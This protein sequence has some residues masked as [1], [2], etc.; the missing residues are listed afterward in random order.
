VL[1]GLTL[2]AGVAAAQTAPAQDAAAVVVEPVVAPSEAF[3]IHG[4]VHSGSTKLPGVT[5]TA[6][7][8]LTGRKVITSTD[9]DGSFRIELPFKGRWALRAEFFAFAV[10]T[11]EL[12]LTP[13][14]PQATHDFE[15]VLQSRVP[16]TTGEEGGAVD[17][18]GGEKQRAGGS[19]VSGR[20]A[21]RLS[22]NADDAALAQSASAGEGDMSPANVSGLAASEDATNQSVSVSGRMGNAQDLGVPNMDD[23]RDRIAEM[24]ASGQLGAGGFDGGGGGQGG[25]GFG[26][27]GGGGGPG[28]G[29]GGRMRMGS[30][31]KPHGQIYYTAS[32][33]VLDAAPY[34]VSGPAEKPAYG[35]NKIGA[36]I[37][38]VLKIPH[39]YDDGGK[40]F[41]FLNYSGIRS[42]TPYDVFSHV[43]TQEERNG[44]FANTFVNGKQVELYDPTNP[45]KLLG[46]GT[47][48]AGTI[49]PAS[50]I[51]SQANALL[52]YIPLPNVTNGPLQN[53]HFSS[54]AGA[55]QDIFSLRLTHNFAAPIGQRGNSGAPGG[56]GGGRGGGGRPR[57][58]LSFGLNYQ[59]NELDNLEPFPLIYGDTHTNGFNANVGWAVS[60]GKLSNQLRFTWNRSRS[61]ADS[62]FAGVTDVEGHPTNFPGGVIG[63][64]S[65]DP[66]NWGLPGLAFSHYTSIS[67]ISPSQ[68]DSQT[69]TLSES[70]GWVRG[71]HHMHFGTD[72]RWIDNKAYASSN[73]RGS[74]T[75]TGSSTAS[76]AVSGSGYDF[77][78]FLLGYAQQTSLA[79]SA[80]HDEFLAHSYDFFAQDDW[81]A[82]GNLTLNFGLRYEFITPFQEAHDHLS[83]LD[84]N[85][86]GLQFADMVPVTVQPNGTGPFHGRYGR[87]LL[88]PDRTNFAPRIGVAW[89]PFGSKTVVRAGYGINYNLGQYA[90]IA[91][92]LAA[93]PPFAVSLTNAAPAGAPS[94]YTLENGFSTPT[95]NPTKPPPP[96]NNFGIDPNYRTAY[97][98]LWNLNVQHELTPTLLLNVGYTGSKGTALDML[99]APNRSPA[100]QKFSNIEA[101]NWETSQG[102]SILHAGSVR[103]RKR[104]TN[105]VAVGG[106]YTYAKS[107]D[108]ASSIGGGAQVVAQ[109]D[110][111][112]R[113]ERGLSSFDQRHK[114]TGDWTLELPW[115]EG[116]K[117]LTRPGIVQ[118][119]F[120]DWLLQSSFTVASGTPFTAR[121]LG[122]F[123]DVAGGTNGTLRANYTGEPIQSG[124]HSIKHWFNTDAFKAPPPGAYGTSGRNTIIG[125]GSAAFNLVLS[126]N[127]PLPNSMGVEMRA[128]AD[129]VLNH[130]NYSGLDTTVNSPTFG[131]VTSVA[132][133]RKM[134]LSVHYRF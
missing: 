6:A 114:L 88:N 103:L 60:K 50:L 35:S 30:M 110:T 16:K 87:G 129:N 90:S 52:Q 57:N 82:R 64:V 112:L 126:K 118:K 115:G 39:V 131:Q 10:Q 32:N 134:I 122:S 77:A 8:S 22:V 40:T 56:G 96:T 104:M 78:D 76:P 69:Y 101:F 95:L 49:V 130:P 128:E 18:Q 59:R 74:F 12:M 107:I 28:G 36:S 19:T 79:Y 111:N 63:G 21:Q 93:Q 2:T 20:G 108:N 83:N 132:S 123:S 17:Q 97:V 99:R 81:R 5:V 133:M 98:Q 14:Q 119:A 92:N 41:V 29:G 116:R 113:A 109:D 120:G 70:F 105:G 48:G 46:A 3:A 47:P 43:P 124:D 125:P 34:S 27:G 23:L 61:H 66:L 55:D 91:Q 89:K 42:S 25:G 51:S 15:M 7:H 11:A 45:G 13:A 53:F 9:V 65:E 38:G 86:N 62:H 44:D 71:K 84:A 73:P 31:T 24:R 68:R 121:V 80:V 127:F 72:Y 54:A 26:M 37:G 85:F 4:V 117:W 102:S 75:F 94:P 58:N 33:A 67:D 100:G 1:L 106:T